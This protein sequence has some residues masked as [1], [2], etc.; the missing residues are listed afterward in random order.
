MFSEAVSNLRPVSLSCTL[1]QVIYDR[2][3][4][5]VKCPVIFICPPDHGIEVDWLIWGQARQMVRFQGK[6]PGS[7]AG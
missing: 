1:S 6:V 5:Y 4:M 3:Y 7:C 2:K